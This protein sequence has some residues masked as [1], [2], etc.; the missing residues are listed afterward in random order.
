MVLYSRPMSSNEME[1]EVQIGGLRDSGRRDSRS[2]SRRQPASVRLCN[3]NTITTILIPDR[4]G[5]N[6]MAIWA[7]DGTQADF[8]WEWTCIW[9]EICKK[10]CSD[11]M[12]LTRDLLQFEITGKIKKVFD[13]MV[14][15]SGFKKREFVIET[16][17]RFPQ[18]IKFEVLKDK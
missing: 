9:I 3:S 2:M 1:T 8:V 6:P 7:E 18:E 10:A 15:E 11:I 4:D 14:F 13:E 12:V 17:E 5:I 16:D